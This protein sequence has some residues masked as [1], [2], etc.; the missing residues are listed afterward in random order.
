MI[1]RKAVSS[2]SHAQVPLF[3]FHQWV[4]FRRTALNHPNCYSLPTKTMRTDSSIKKSVLIR[5]SSSLKR[6]T[7]ILKRAGY[8]K[9]K[10]PSVI[11]S[12]VPLAFI[13]TYLCNL[14]IQQRKLHQSQQAANLIL[15]F[16]LL[17]V[18]TIQPLS[19]QSDKLRRFVTAT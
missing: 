18:W 8:H 3:L 2:V 6:N 17:K 13:S 19:L 10:T 15:G 9:A 4:V 11:K 16:Q 14:S 5:K 12:S 1:V 7:L